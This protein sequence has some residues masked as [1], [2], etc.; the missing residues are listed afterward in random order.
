MT[1][2]SLPTLRSYTRSMNISD[3]FND[4]YRL[5]IDHVNTYGQ[6]SA[7]RGMPIKEI[8]GYSFTLTNPRNCLCT[9]TA[10]KLNY[11]FAIIEKM[12][13]AGGVSR[14]DRIV[15]YNKNM[16]SFINEKTGEFDGAY[17]PRLASQIPYVIEL[18]KRDPDSRQAVLNINGPQDKHA[19]K[20]VPCTVAL[21][22]LLRQGKLHMIVYMRSNDLLWGTPY[23]VNGFCF[24]L[25]VI[26]SCLGVEMGTYT[27]IAG[28]MHMYLERKDQMLTLLDD[29]RLNDEKNPVFDIST[30]DETLRQINQRFFVSEW[31]L[32]QGVSVE[33]VKNDGIT[34]ELSPA[35]R[36]YFDRIA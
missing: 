25:E 28:S 18:L 22:L 36:T 21:Q 30:Y 35:M 16:S 33:I 1:A 26:A 15:R 29:S 6:E 9:L 27:H 13:Y 7:P 14:P 34:K 12:E 31:S 3:N 19:T 4:C 8:I 24:L 2:P 23:D 10:R 11:K 5:A 17:G 32:S 20:D